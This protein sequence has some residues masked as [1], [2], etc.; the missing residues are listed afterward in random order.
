MA[1]PDRRVNLAVA[2]VIPVVLLGAVIYASYAITKP[3]CIDYLLH[4]LPKYDRR[5][6]TGAGIAIIVIYYVLLFPVVATYI[7]LLYNVI[8]NPGLLPRNSPPAPTSQG[9]ERPHSRRRSSHRRRQS[10]EQSRQSEKSEGAGADVEQGLEYNAGNPA[11]QIDLAGLENFYRKDVFVC[12]PDGR[13]LYCSTCCHYK[14]DRA[15][16]CR[17]VD[18]CVRKMDHFCPWVGGVVSETSFKFFIQFVFY[19]MVFCLFCLIVCAYFVAEIKRDSGSVNP[20]WAV[21]IGLSGLFGLFTFGMTLSS[22]QLGMFNLSTIENINRQ[23][24]VWTLAIRVPNHVLAKLH[25]ETQWAPTFRTITYPLPSIPPH[26]EFGAEYQ[27]Y[28][29]PAEQHVF[30]ILQT[31][32]GDNPFDLGSPIKNLQQIM[33]YSLFD[34][35]LPLKHSP[36]AD[37]TNQESTFAFGPV[38]SRLKQDAGL[39]SS[40][41]TEDELGDH[42]SSKHKRKRRKHRRRD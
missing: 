2:R 24:V 6:R 31:Q 40:V 35:M 41:E 9:P 23:S 19:T 27:H 13:P 7:R 15:H 17:E 25:P 11:F 14:P 36:C 12:Q 39:D 32:P 4:P 30:A 26:A 21:G 29:P 42:R 5:P 20:H 37:H 3:L 10:H 22:L 34:W 16:H 1:R 28:Q 38:V 18:R 33:G 8:W